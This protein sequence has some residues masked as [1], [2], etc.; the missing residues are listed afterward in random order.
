M[1]ELSMKVKAFVIVWAIIL[2][3]VVCATLAS[4]AAIVLK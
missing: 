1:N 3:A 4:V 2:A